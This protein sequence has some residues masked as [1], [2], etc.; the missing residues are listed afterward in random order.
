VH[1]LQRQ[2]KQQLLLQQQK[3]KRRA[4]S[5]PVRPTLLD[6]RDLLSRKQLNHAAL[7]AHMRR[8]RLD[9]ASRGGRPRVTEKSVEDISIVSVALGLQL[10]LR[11]PD[12]GYLLWKAF[13]MAAMDV[14]VSVDAEAE[15]VSHQEFNQ[16]LVLAAP[17]ARISNARRLRM[18]DEAWEERLKRAVIAGNPRRGAAAFAAVE[19]ASK[20]WFMAS[21]YPNDEINIIVLAQCVD[22]HLALAELPLNRATRAHRSY[23]DAVRAVN[24][25]PGVTNH[26]HTLW[27]QHS[28]LSIAGEDDDGPAEQNRHRRKM[29]RARTQNRAANVGQGHVGQSATAVP[30]KLALEGAEFRA[31]ADRRVLEADKEKRRRQHPVAMPSPRSAQAATAARVS[32]ESPQARADSAAAPPASSS[33][34]EPQSSAGDTGPSDEASPAPPVKIAVYAEWPEY[35]KVDFVDLF[36]NQ[37]AA[38]QLRHLEENPALKDED[39]MRLFPGEMALKRELDK[40]A[41]PVPELFFMSQ[42][43]TQGMLQFIDQNLRPA[44]HLDIAAGTAPFQLLITSP[45][46]LGGLDTRSYHVRKSAGK[47]PC[48]VYVNV[49]FIER[50]THL[51]PFQNTWREPYAH[52]VLVEGP[53]NLT[54]ML[55]LQRGTDGGERR[56]L[57]EIYRGRSDIAMYSTISGPGPVQANT[58]RLL[59]WLRASLN[60][61][62]TRATFILTWWIV[63][64]HLFWTVLAV[65]SSMYLYGAAKIGRA[66]VWYCL[67]LLAIPPAYFR[68]VRGMISRLSEEVVQ[69]P[70][71]AI[72]DL[73]FKAVIPPEHTPRAVALRD[74]FCQRLHALA[75]ALQRGVI[76]TISLL[77]LLTRPLQWVSLVVTWIFLQL[78]GA[79]MIA[80]L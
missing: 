59:S 43:S 39:F 48:S 34:A 14:R 63:I 66:T 60:L 80:L 61:Q 32:S 20:M 42:Q 55:A 2:N 74:R 78:V 25:P 13:I 49:R 26:E 1:P 70:D 16:A 53:V 75:E 67:L 31:E 3:L 5:A 30:P 79:R 35:R 41:A 4:A 6:Y 56:E 33:A 38:P 11:D 64:A 19:T 46:Y 76:V 47:V 50:D 23:N 73:V 68:Y 27:M 28:M 52:K 40:L 18:F 9:A 58:C 7:T 24:K 8:Q 57:E 29:Y 36:Q 65:V 69:S 54:L 77:R 71:C 72:S 37:P 45:V 62:E 22:A 12:R 15:N 17:A 21:Y 51:L 10:V 44:N